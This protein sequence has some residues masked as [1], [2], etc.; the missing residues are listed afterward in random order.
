[1]NLRN[2]IPG[3]IQR[4]SELTGMPVAKIA[5]LRRHRR[6]VAIRW[7]IFAAARKNGMSLTEIGDE[8][9]MDHGTVM[10][11][12]RHLPALVEQDAWVR[13]LYQQMNDQVEARDQ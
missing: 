6:Q 5:E 1:M 3:L 4:A 13:E 2:P 8:F 10:H 11:G 7:V 12:L 9:G